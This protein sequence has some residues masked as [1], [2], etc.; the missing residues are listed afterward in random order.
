[1]NATVLGLVHA[2]LLV[3]VVVLASSKSCK[4][5]FRRDRGTLNYPPSPSKYYRRNVNCEWL[6]KPQEEPSCD[7]MTVTVEYVDTEKDRDILEIVDSSTNRVLE[8]LSGPALY[9]SST[10]EEYQGYPRQYVAC[11]AYMTIRFKSDSNWIMGRG[12]RIVYTTHSTLLTPTVLL[13]MYNYL[14]L[15]GDAVKLRTTMSRYVKAHWTLCGS[16]RRQACLK[17][18]N[19]VLESS[20]IYAM[21]TARDGIVDRIRI[22]DIEGPLKTVTSDKLITVE[23]FQKKSAVAAGHCGNRSY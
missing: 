4:A 20:S 19:V 2:L 17:F 6:L 23:I 11:S 3:P 1:M 8:I 14:H 16:N 13:Y 22:N 9:S 12:F 5:D 18:Y 7:R 10:S 15:A 21:V